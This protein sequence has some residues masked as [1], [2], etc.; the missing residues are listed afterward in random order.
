MKKF[1]IVSF[2][3]IFSG[4]FSS[5]KQKQL[6]ECQNISIKKIDIDKI[7]ENSTP[8]IKEYGFNVKKTPKGDLI[9][10][11]PYWGDAYRFDLE[12][13]KKWGLSFN[14]KSLN[15]EKDRVSFLGSTTPDFEIVDENIFFLQSKN[16]ISEYSLT[17]EE[18]KNHHLD[19][20][21]F[22]PERIKAFNQKELLIYGLMLNNSQSFLTFYKLDIKNG[23]L[24]LIHKIKL[25]SPNNPPLVNL[26]D[27]GVYLLEDNGLTLKQLNF[28]EGIIREISLENS[29]LRDYLI[30]KVPEG[31]DYWSLDEEQRLDYKND[32]T[33]KLILSKDEIYIL[34]ELNRGMFKKQ[35]GKLLTK[36][37]FTGKLIDELIFENQIVEI[38]ECG[39]IFKIDEINGRNYLLQ[40]EN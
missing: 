7:T 31:V 14:S 34:H 6:L 30:Y 35:S 29:R 11:I 10:F 3:L 25:I 4:C 15:E 13:N 40:E 36:Y 12:E 16:L 33:K 37:N 20:Q 21:G 17:G 23:D 2:I 8:A 24:E 9:F 27:G 39:N 19:I 22:Y 5:G 32:K 38:D 18:L 1:V 26:Y 28:K